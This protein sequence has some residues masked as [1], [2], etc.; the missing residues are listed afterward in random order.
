M[1][2]NSN[3]TKFPSLTP[4]FR[5]FTLI[6]LLVVIAII[7]ILAGLLLPALAK[8]KQKAQR[9][10]CLN[11]MKQFGLGS[12]MYADENKGHLVDNTHTYSKPGTA[13]TAPALPSLRDEADDDLNWLGPLGRN[14]I[15]NY[16]S[17]ICP[18][19]KNAID[20]TKPQGT[21]GPGDSAYF[22]KYIQDLAIGATD[23]NDTSGHSYEVKGNINTPAG[24]KKMTQN[25]VLS[26]EY[27][28][29]GT[30]FK[31]GPSG[32]W[33]IQDFDGDGAVKLA[34]NTGGN[35]EPTFNDAH[36]RDGSNFTYADGHS[37]WV[38]RAKWLFNYN[39][40]RNLN[41]SAF[42]NP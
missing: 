35:N 20:L 36:G 7:A 2:I 17:F 32:I 21:Y 28:S 14:F 42:V 10:S 27:T 9:I 26:Y 1:N 4:Q 11:N 19:T 39:I 40:S 8:A 37:A 5:G 38:P 18:S 41:K 29:T 12:Q 31:P 23:I 25:F 22:Q 33:F 15:S 30:P 3:R 34:G 13:F 16:K 24:R 6:E